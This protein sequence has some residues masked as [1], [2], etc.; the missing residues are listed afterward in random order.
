MATITAVT[1]L[2]LT[3][4]CISQNARND[5]GRDTPPNG[6]VLMEQILGDMN[7]TPQE[8]VLKRIAS[9][10]DIRLCKVLNIRRQLTEGTYEVAG[11]LD[12]AIDRV[13]E[14]IAA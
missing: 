10:P 2:Q 5:Q 4:R 8:E 7:T 11:R 9:L 13:L 1:E 12:R 6:D 3:D 14:E